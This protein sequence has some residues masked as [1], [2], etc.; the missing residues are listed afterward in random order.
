MG[1]PLVDLDELDETGE[2]CN[3]AEAP[4]LHLRRMLI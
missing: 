1:A 2:S 4:D 3:G